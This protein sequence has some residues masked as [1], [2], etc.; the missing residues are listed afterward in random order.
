M[1]E[2]ALRVA[3]SRLR[4]DFRDVLLKELKAK[5][6]EWRIR[7]PSTGGIIGAA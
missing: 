1:T 4:K 6:E 5:N 3:L 7:N 2:N